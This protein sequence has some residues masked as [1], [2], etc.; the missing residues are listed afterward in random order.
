MGVPVGLVEATGEQDL[1]ALPFA[2]ERVGRG[3]G[4]AVLIDATCDLTRVYATTL[5]ALPT[6][7]YGA[8][9]GQKSKRNKMTLPSIY[10]HRGRR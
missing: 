2:V 8:P 1:F 5:G 4:E 3:R 9:N 6:M 10:L 7:S